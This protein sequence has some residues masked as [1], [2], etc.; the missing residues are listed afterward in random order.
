MLLSWCQMW[1]L[2]GKERFLYTGRPCWSTQR[3][4]EIKSLEG[5]FSSTRKKP[6][7]MVLTPTR[8]ESLL[9]IECHNQLSGVIRSTTGSTCWS[10]LINLHQMTLF[11]RKLCP[12]LQIFQDISTK[13][14]PLGSPVSAIKL[15]N[16]YLPSTIITNF[17]W[18]DYVIYSSAD[19]HCWQCAPLKNE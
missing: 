15:A 12:S 13:S 5:R 6:R 18:F 11:R 7:M 16:L 8:V 19:A 17:C 1:K 14:T 9:L 10:S 3:T 2:H 4:I